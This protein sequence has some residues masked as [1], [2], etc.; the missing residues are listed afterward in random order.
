MLMALI[1]VTIASLAWLQ[2][3]YSDWLVDYQSN[4][5]DYLTPPLYVLVDGI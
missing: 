1:M 4:Q 3:L 2:A 5:A